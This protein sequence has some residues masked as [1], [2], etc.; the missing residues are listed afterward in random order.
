MKN[1]NLSELETQHA[2]LLSIGEFSTC[3]EDFHISDYSG[4]GLSGVQTRVLDL[5][6]RFSRYEE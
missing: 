5:L 4:L 2:C 6:S 3:R 1:E